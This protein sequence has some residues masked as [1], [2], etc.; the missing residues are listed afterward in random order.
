[1][2]KGHEWIRKVVSLTVLVFALKLLFG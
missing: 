1:V 2:K